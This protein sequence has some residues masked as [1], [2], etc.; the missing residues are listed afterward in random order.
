MTPLYLTPDCPM[1]IRPQS[2]FAFLLLLFLLTACGQNETPAGKPQ[3]PP[4]QVKVAQPLSREVSEWDT[5]TGRIEAIDSVDVRAKV[6]GYLEKI[7]FKAGQRVNKG[8]LLFAI[9]PKPFQ[10][11]LN[12]AQAELERE[13]TRRELAQNDLT[14]AENLRKARAISAEEYDSRSK[15]LKEAIAS[16]HSAEANVFA[17]KLNLEYSQIRSP[18]DGRVGRELV[19]LGN[20][21]NGGGSATLLTTIVSTDP[22]YVMIDADERSILKYKRQH[23]NADGL[24]AIEAELSLADESDFPHKGTFNYIAPQADVDTGTVRLRGVFDNLEQLLSPGFYCRIRIR[25]GA[26]YQALLLPDKALGT[27]QAQRFV[28]VVGKDNQVDYRKVI[29]GAR[30]GDMRV[31]AQGVTADDWVVT[32]G[33]MKIRPGATVNPERITLDGAQ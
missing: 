2:C 32:E 9:D 16:V 5:F 28:W 11:Q 10:A 31:I 4:A 25:A 20:L 7:N 12:L 14:R 33:L 24:I 23:A 22:V 29:V 17:A 30:I 15:G 26:P 19:T 18:I 21:V 27:D 1:L 8:D 13:K 3:M 6:S